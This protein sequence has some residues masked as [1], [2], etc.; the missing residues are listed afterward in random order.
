MTRRTN[1][2]TARV[3]RHLPILLILILAAV[4]RVRGIGDDSLWGD[5]GLTI[6]LAKMRIPELIRGV[7]SFEQIP[8]VHHL[9]V[10]F[11]MMLFG[12]SE[13]SVRMPSA[14]AGVAAVY[15]G[16]VLVTRLVGRRVA[17]ITAELMATSPMLIAYSQECRAYSMS[18]FL[19]L[20][21]CDLF[22]RLM[23]RPTQRLHVAYVLVTAL[24][25]Y[26]HVYGLFTILAQQIIYCDVL[27]QRGGRVRLRPKELII[28]GVAVLAL[29]SPWIPIVRTWTKAIQAGFWV[30][31]VTFDDV[32]RAYW[33]YS[34][35]TAAFIVIVALVVIGVWSWR[36]R[37]HLRGRRVG[38]AMLMALMFVPVVVPVTISVLTRPSFAPRYAIMSTIGMLAIAAFG[39]TAIRPA[40]L[41]WLVLAAVAIMSPFGDAAVIPRAPWREVG[42]FL[43]ENVRA[44]DLV[45]I[46]LRAGTRLY[47]YYVDRPDVRRVGMDTVGLP[48]AYP[49]EPR[50]VWLVVYDAFPWYT[51]NQIIKRHPVKIGRREFTW[52]V[53]ALEL[54]EDPERVHEIPPF[55]P[56]TETIPPPMRPATTTTTTATTATT[57]ST[58]APR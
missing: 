8:P 56:N 3:W 42:Q 41:R 12:D 33:T 18:V 2:S 45:V 19:G 54:I 14:I 44:N 20:W 49:Y 11:W 40:A 52:G 58:T 7:I 53:M 55:D 4:L 5:E 32:S 30:K 57:T 51:A 1:P 34:G 39:I 46:H 35:S 17:L 15:V 38:F 47:D 43:Q 28:D 27:W 31:K 50:R 21:S 36:R 37:P 13:T 10:H 22:I 29:Y 26:T 9:T 23:R 48:V 24:L 6:L 25:I 16:Y